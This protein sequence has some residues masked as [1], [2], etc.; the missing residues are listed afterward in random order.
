V[1]SELEV[2]PVALRAALE[3]VTLGGRV[4]VL[5][6]HSGEDRLVKGAFREAVNGGCT[7]PPGLPCVCGAY[8][9]FK[10]VVRGGARPSDGE[11]SGSPRSRSARLRC[12][13]R[14]GEAPA[15]PG[16]GEF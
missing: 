13:E 3:R 10:S 4:V 14:V 6:Y 7:C 16:G 11:T 2:L 15:G 5:S 12:V 9:Q 8:P 1:N